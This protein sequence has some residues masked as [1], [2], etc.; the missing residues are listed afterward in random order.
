MNW[1]LEVDA[2]FLLTL[3]FCSGYSTDVVAKQVQVFQIPCR[4]LLTVNYII[5][6]LAIEI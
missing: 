6:Y 1:L 4:S 3:D 5:I 2:G